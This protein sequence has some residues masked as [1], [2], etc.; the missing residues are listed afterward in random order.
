MRSMYVRECTGMLP[1][2]APMY[3]YDFLPEEV[4]CPLRIT[5]ALEIGASQSL[6]PVGSQI[7]GMAACTAHGRL[8]LSG[9]GF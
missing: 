1:G 6:I 5:P 4:C 7:Q 8:C 2:I 9:G 3:F